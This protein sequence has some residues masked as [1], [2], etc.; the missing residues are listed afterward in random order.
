M[1]PAATATNRLQR[2]TA[3]RLPQ[4]KFV[5]SEKALT[6]SLRERWYNVTEFNHIHLFDGDDWVCGRS[7]AFDDQ[8]LLRCE[9]RSAEE[10][11]AC[12]QCIAQ[13]LAHFGEAMHIQ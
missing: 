12:R 4:P 2:L 10:D 8:E 9:A 7:M 5:Q 1:S 3:L 6:A 13:L 11:S